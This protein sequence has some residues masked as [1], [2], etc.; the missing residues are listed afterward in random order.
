MCQPPLA[1]AQDAPFPQDPGYDP[2]T[3]SDPICFKVANDTD[4]SIYAQVISNYYPDDEGNWVRHRHNFRIAPDDDPYPVCTT[5]PF[6]NERDML[7]QIKSLIPILTC[8]FDLGDGGR[9]L[10]FYHKV[11]QD[12]VRRLWANCNVIYPDVAP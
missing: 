2:K 12:G 7:V 11:T 4:Q 3:T 8:E 1:L 10:R 5:G 6:Y 9:T